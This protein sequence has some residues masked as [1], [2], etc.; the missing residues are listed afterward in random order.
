MARIKNNTAY[1]YDLF[2]LHRAGLR[3][4][5]AGEN[6]CQA[7]LRHTHTFVHVMHKSFRDESPRGKETL[8]I[9]IIQG[10]FLCTYNTFS[11]R[12]C[13][14]VLFVYKNSKKFSQHIST[15]TSKNVFLPKGKRREEKKENSCRNFI[16]IIHFIYQQ[17]WRRYKENESPWDHAPTTWHFNQTDVVQWDGG[18]MGGQRPLMELLAGSYFLLL[19]PAGGNKRNCR[20][21]HIASAIRFIVLL[22]L[23]VL[24]MAVPL[25]LPGPFSQLSSH[26]PSIHESCVHS[27]LFLPTDPHDF[28]RDFS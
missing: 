20:W 28:R 24:L 15:T 2:F 9:I 10:R 4:I 12:L 3:D 6:C 5:K 27:K 14:K 13:Q 26:T 23:G 25:S 22:H 18:D 8:L 16:F 21:I 11:P 19:L 7:S 1:E 17:E